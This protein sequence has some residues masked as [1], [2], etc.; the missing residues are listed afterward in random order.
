MLPN[1]R[2]AAKLQDAVGPSDIIF[3]CLADE[4]ATVA[5]YKDIL[6]LSQDLK[7][8]LFV[9]CTTISPRATDSISEW[10]SAVSGRFIAMPG[11]KQ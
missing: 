7:G 6:S 4:D 5:I 10:I 11:T 1:S 9:D 2:V 3:T 8:K